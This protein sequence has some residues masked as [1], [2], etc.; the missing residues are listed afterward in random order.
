M[1]NNLSLGF[2]ILIM[3]LFLI[4]GISSTAFQRLAMYFPVTVSILGFILTGTYNALQIRNRIKTPVVFSDE[5]KNEEK[6]YFVGSLRYLAWFVG[7]IVL[8]YIAG[9]LISTAVFLGAFLW[10]EA[11]MRWWGVLI[12]IFS[13]LV[14]LN[15]ISATM[16]LHWPRNV[17]GLW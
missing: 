7:Y 12:S 8:I 5:N 15:I 9:I 2:G 6:D 3:I 11:K 10:F 4:T 17:L 14:V 1:R 16:K 13:S